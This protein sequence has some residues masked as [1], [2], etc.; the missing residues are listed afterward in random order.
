VFGFVLIF[1]TSVCYSTP[2]EI[3][4]ST[5]DPACN[6]CRE[7]YDNC[8]G[9][10]PENLSIIEK[11]KEQCVCLGTYVSCL[12]HASCYRRETNSYTDVYERCNILQ[13]E[14]ICPKVNCNPGFHPKIKE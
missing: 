2:Q 14:G 11:L 7:D 6:T 8:V 4:D 12:G 1:L 10:L 9:L 3:V 13:G 5:D